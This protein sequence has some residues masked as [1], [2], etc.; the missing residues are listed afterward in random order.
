MTSRVTRVAVPI[1][2]VALLAGSAA[3]QQEPGAGPFG[4]GGQP[5]FR[6]RGVMPPRD[7]TPAPVGKARITGR[8]LSAESG[9]PIRRAQISLTSRDARVNRNV[10]TDAEGRYELATL[11]TGR[12]RLSVSKAGYVPL[13]Y[14]QA[15]PFEAGKPLDLADG[16]LLEKIDFSLPRGSVITGRITDEFGDPI[17]DVQVQALRFQFV[18][19]ERQ[20]VTSGRVA[21]TDD[22]GQY[23]IFGLMPGE[24][25]VH[26]SLREMPAAARETPSDASGY[27]GT[28]FPGVADASQAQTVSVTIGQELSAIGFPLVPARFARVAGV[29]LASDGRPLGGAI[30]VI[31]PRM[32]GS[33]LGNLVGG[34]GR[35]AADAEGRFSLAR[36]PPGEYVLDV[37]QRPDRPQNVTNAVA[38]LEFASLPLT[39]SDDVENLTITTTAGI[40]LSGRVVY[41][42]QNPPRTS[43]QIMAI[44]P[45][46]APGLR[47][48]AGRALGSGRVSGDGT[49]DIHGLFGPQLLRPQ[50]V[51]T[52]WTLKSV[53]VNGTDVTDMPFDFRPGS[54]ITGAVITLTDRVSEVSGLVLDARGQI[55]SD[56]V[57][58]VF[59]EDAKLWGAQ[60]RHVQTTRPNQNGV[61]SIKGLPPG[62][63]LAAAVPSLE[64]GLQNDRGVLERLRSGAEG[65]SLAEGGSANLN[66]RMP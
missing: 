37:Q 55:A 34:G 28:Y 7:N 9:T 16:Q 17:T 41:E 6:G 47:A 66:L 20:L 5:P 54:N 48:L 59:P 60:S 21:R 56:Y 25:V 19:G 1:I 29:V 18:N 23:R 42:G 30:L 22:L 32:S 10:A 15:R 57:L 61:F 64:N 53:E 50:N 40:T 4:R 13:E 49:F 31:R 14:G 39:V 24:Y 33:G 43:F 63:Y 62:R 36:I 52:G 11:P 2:A 65:F 3:G 12:Y 46:G 27:P 38:Q 58:V 44:A 8:V 26:A 45:D 51:P 35:S